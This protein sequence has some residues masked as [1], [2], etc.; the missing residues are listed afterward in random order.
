[1]VAEGRDVAVSELVP[2]N[3]VRPQFDAIMTWY[4]GIESDSVSSVDLASFDDVEVNWAV[5]EGLGSAAA[6]AADGLHVRLATPVHGIEW[7]GRGVT[8][9]TSAGSIEARA[10]IVTAPTS[11]L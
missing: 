8:V 7:L 6:R 5:R 10:V 9:Q 11:L 3:A 4:I 1:A 2:D